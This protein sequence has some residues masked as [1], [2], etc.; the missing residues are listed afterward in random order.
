RFSTKYWDDETGL[1]YWGYRYYDPA[2]GR[3][4]TWDPIGEQGGWSLYG[5]A[6]N[7][8]SVAYDALGQCTTCECCKGHAKPLAAPYDWG[9]V[10]EVDMWYAA[11]AKGC[12]LGRLPK[13]IRDIITKPKHHLPSNYSCLT[14][15][16]KQ[17]HWQSV[18]KHMMSQMDDLGSINYADYKAFLKQA[19]KCWN[20]ADGVKV[21]PTWPFC[22]FIQARVCI[23]VENCPAACCMFWRDSCLK[24]NGNNPCH[25]GPDRE[26]YSG[27]LKDLCSGC[28]VDTCFSARNN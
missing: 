7:G 4:I 9:G 6:S 21:G 12:T 10:S 8:P 23:F 18:Y 19:R 1:G 11:K 14:P 20:K 22:C 3:W 5:F 27:Y 24:G 13:F 26:K 16:Q 25:G 28:D 15:D 2:T 17:A